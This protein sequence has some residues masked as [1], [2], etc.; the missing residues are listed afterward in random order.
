[1]STLDGGP[2]TSTGRVQSD[3]EAV[4][5]AFL[6]RLDALSFVSAGISFDE[7]DSAVSHFAGSEWLK[8]KLSALDDH[9]R[10]EQN[11]SC[12]PAPRECGD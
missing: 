6:V 4:R 7:Q 1:M 8:T 9:A 5:G 10:R 2:L 3:M 12:A 11:E